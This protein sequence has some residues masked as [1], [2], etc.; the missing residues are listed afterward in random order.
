VLFS[1]GEEMRILEYSGTFLSSFFSVVWGYEVG[2][3]LRE[4]GGG[5][6]MAERMYQMRQFN[7][8]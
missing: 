7:T 2:G 6:C 3:E 8:P 1:C 4:G 5:M